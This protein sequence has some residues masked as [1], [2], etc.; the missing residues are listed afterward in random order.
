MGEYSIET[1]N[2]FQLILD[3]EEDVFDIL[4]QEDAKS[5][6]KRADPELNKN[7]KN[8]KHEKKDK[9]KKPGQIVDN[10]N[11]ANIQKAQGKP[12][13]RGNGEINIDLGVLPLG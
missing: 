8:T 7:T 5:D 4:K 6:K 10:A 11:V 9:S 13:F 1:K 2:R 12:A 3:D